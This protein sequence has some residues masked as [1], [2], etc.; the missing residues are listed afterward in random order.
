MNASAKV[1][2]DTCVIV[3]MLLSSRPRHAQADALRKIFAERNILARVPYFAVFEVSHAIRQEK[4]L[5]KATFVPEEEIP[6]ELVPVD[7]KFLKAY[8]D[9]S[10][11]EM[12]AGDLV[13]ASMAH[14]DKLPLVTEDA[15]LAAAAKAAGIDVKSIAEMLAA[16]GHAV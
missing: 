11:P 16:L 5:T 1:I 7:Q 12:R 3:D 4:R 14:K 15:G 10:L 9:E 6:A 13:F 2:V 8:F